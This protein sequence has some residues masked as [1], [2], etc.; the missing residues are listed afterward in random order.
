MPLY[1]EPGRPSPACVDRHQFK[2]LGFNFK[3]V[4]EPGSANPCDYG[5]CHT[6]IIPNINKLTEHE[7]EDLGVEDKIGDSKFMGNRV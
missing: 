3:V 1:N 7:K 4:Y 5:S 2:L 6:K